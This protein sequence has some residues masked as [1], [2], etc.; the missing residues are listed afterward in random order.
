MFKAKCGFSSIMPARSI[1][2][3]DLGRLIRNKNVSVIDN[4]VQRLI[5]GDKLYR[6]I[7]CTLERNKHICFRI[8][9]SI[10]ESL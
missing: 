6:D 8:G 2:N 9:N 1:I 10:G 5:L 4:S 7:C 3:R